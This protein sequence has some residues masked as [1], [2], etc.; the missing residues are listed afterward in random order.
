MESFETG[1]RDQRTTV[2]S[3]ASRTDDDKCS[4]QQLPASHLDRLAHLVNDV[5]HGLLALASHAEVLRS[6]VRH[7]LQ[8]QAVGRPGVLGAQVGRNPFLDV[9]VAKVA[10]F[11]HEAHRASFCGSA[12]SMP[13]PRQLAVTPIGAR[14][15]VSRARS[16]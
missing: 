12:T 6:L 7:D 8:V 13:S 16:P 2:A 5:L 9:L 14:C 11:L 10:Y 3:S 4:G 1:E 15:R